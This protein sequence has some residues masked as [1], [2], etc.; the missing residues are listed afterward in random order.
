MDQTWWYDKD[1][2]RRGPFSASQL[3]AL[4]QEGVLSTETLVS[5]STTSKP[6]WVAL[7]DAPGL[8]VEEL[9]PIAPGVDAADL[10]QMPPPAA[11]NSFAAATVHEAAA[12]LGA[13]PSSGIGH[14]AAEPTLPL[15]GPWRRFFARVVDGAVFAYPAAVLF[16][17]LI[18]WAS[19]AFSMWLQSPNSRLVAPVFVL[20]F[21]LAIEAVI[22]GL[23]GTTPGK[24]LLGVQV[25]TL[26]GGRP[27]FGQFATRLAGLYWRGLAVGVLLVNF[28]T[29]GRQYWLVRKGRPTG[30]DK[31]SFHVIARPLSRVRAVGA[32]AVVLAAVAFNQ[33]MLTEQRMSRRDYNAGFEW[34]NPVSGGTAAIP[35]GWLYSNRE[36]ETGDPLFT[37]SSDKLGVVGIFGMEEGLKEIS[38]EEYRNIWTSVVSSDMLIDE[39]VETVSVNGRNTLQSHGTMATNATRR[40]H[41]TLFKSGDQIWRLV[42]VGLPGRAP[43]GTL[44]RHLR[45]ALVSTVPERTEAPTPARSGP[46]GRPI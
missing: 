24:K 4:W 21:A 7:K 28:C 32:A 41:V 27:T 14:A 33:G 25:T 9:T 29:M 1:Q 37:F 20:P 42:L 39:R 18:D 3:L 31:D 36:N 15:A 35:P 6:V 11:G 30:Y 26:S 2:E 16:R 19:P 34:R 38:V 23:L 12:V 17:L 45:E 5:N 13:L 46:V 10:A 43:D 44:T 8:S 40:V 22:A